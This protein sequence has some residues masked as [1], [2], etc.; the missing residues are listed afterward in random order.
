MDQMQKESFYD[1]EQMA[2][3]PGPYRVLILPY[4]QDLS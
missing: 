1:V 4:C 3:S 2:F